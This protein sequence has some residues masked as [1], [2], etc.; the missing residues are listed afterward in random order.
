MSSLLALA[1]AHASDWSL[2]IDPTAHVGPVYAVAVSPTGA[3]TASI[4]ADGTLR[5]WI[6]EL[7]EALVVRA[8]VQ[9]ARAPPQAPGILRD[10][11][12]SLQ[13]VRKC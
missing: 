3:Q 5:F 2:Q 10:P 8:P 11:S 6:P 9:P 12:P 13:G 1:S 7:G 4:G